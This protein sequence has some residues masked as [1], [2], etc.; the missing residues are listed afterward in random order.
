MNN[1]TIFCYQILAKYSPNRTKLHH[2]KNNSLGSI[3]PNPPNKRV[4]SSRAA[5]RLAPCKYPHIYK[6]IL[7]PPPKIKS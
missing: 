5:W 2:F 3:P 4:S 7:N 1:F 6:N